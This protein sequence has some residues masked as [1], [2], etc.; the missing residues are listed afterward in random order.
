MRPESRVKREALLTRCERTLRTSARLGQTVAGKSERSG[1]STCARWLRMIPD[2]KGMT[3][4]GSERG[5][6]SPLSPNFWRMST[7]K[8]R[9]KMLLVVHMILAA[10]FAIDKSEQWRQKHRTSVWE[11]DKVLLLICCEFVFQSTPG[12]SVE[13]L[14]TDQ[15]KQASTLLI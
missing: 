7:S 6:F 2:L 4:A 10:A 9:W 14:G 1:A 11:K 8:I 15:I 3:P 5:G 13:I 12:V